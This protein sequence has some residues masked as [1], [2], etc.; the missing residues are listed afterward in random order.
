MSLINILV[1]LI[2]S[3]D[4]EYGRAAPYFEKQKNRRLLGM[5]K[6]GGLFYL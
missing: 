4:L 6:K 5:P 2:D 3:V 1:S